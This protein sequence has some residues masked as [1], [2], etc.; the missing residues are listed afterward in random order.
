MPFSDDIIER[1]K[2]NTFF[3]GVLATGPHSQVVIDLRSAGALS[4]HDHQTRAEAEATEAGHG[5]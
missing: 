2:Q 1:A 5:R 3:R 4:R